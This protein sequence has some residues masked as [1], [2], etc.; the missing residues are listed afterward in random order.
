MRKKLIIGG[1]TLA[2]L[3][4]FPVLAN[5]D[6]VN[7]FKR[8]F[9]ANPSGEQVYVNQDGD[10][11]VM[12]KPEAELELGRTFTYFAGDI[13]GTKVGTTTTGEEWYGSHVATSSKIVRTGGMFNTAIITNMATEASSTG[14]II[15]SILGSNDDECDT[16]STTTT[17]DFVVTGD[18][19]WF[20]LGIHTRELAGSQ[21]G[22]AATSTFNLSFTEPKQTNQI[23]LQDLNYECLK[24]IASGKTVSLWTQLRMK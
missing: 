7:N 2:I 8:L 9:L 6:V 13:F 22:T 14:N 24:F 20:D 10:V 16:A 5:E 4:C 11:Y 1:I 17:G 12:Q 23:I 18:I 15:M 3:L 21:T 19:N